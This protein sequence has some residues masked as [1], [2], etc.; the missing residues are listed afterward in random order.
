MINGGS[1]APADPSQSMPPPIPPVAEVAPVGPIPPPPTPVGSMPPVAPMGGVP[2]DPNNPPPIPPEMGGGP[3]QQPAQKKKP[4]IMPAMLAHEIAR[5]YA[6]RAVEM[7][8]NVASQ[9]GPPDGA[10]PYSTQKQILMWRARDPDVDVE[11]MLA[12]GKSRTEVSKL[13]Y[14]LRVLLM[15]LSGR[16]P[17][18]RVRY[19]QHMKRITEKYD[20]VSYDANDPSGET[21]GESDSYD[22]QDTSDV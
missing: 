11:G 7:A 6:D 3:P 19:A 9:S 18:E 16:T 21:L 20:D 10:I 5:Q 4:M 14:P 8:A 2:V 1:F 13:A 17:L 15:K 22:S 12:E